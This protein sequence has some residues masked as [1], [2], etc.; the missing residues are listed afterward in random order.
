MDKYCIRQIRKDDYEKQ[1]LHLLQ[2]LT[3][4][5]PDKITKDDFDSFIDNLNNNHVI[6]VIEHQETN[7]IIGSATLLV[8]HKIIHNMGIVCHIEDVVIDNKFRGENLGKRL[9][10]ELIRISKEL[11]C[12][13][14]ILDCAKHNVPF[15]EK[16]GFKENGV[17]MSLYM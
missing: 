8:E 7:T 5:E 10:N 11:N 2:Q 13:K 15:Y 12:Y 9:I 6:F 3:T 4:I 16:C 14:I 1:Y 17:E